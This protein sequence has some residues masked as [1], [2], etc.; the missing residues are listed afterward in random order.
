[1]AT[2]MTLERV[3]DAAQSKGWNRDSL[4]RKR[5]KLLRER[6]VLPVFIGDLFLDLFLELDHAPHNQSGRGGE[7]RS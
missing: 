2:E 4:L 1:M 7:R 5:V 6:Y 3:S